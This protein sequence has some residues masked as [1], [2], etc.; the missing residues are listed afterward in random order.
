M[1]VFV[2]YSTDD[3]TSFYGTYFDVEEARKKIANLILLELSE[4]DED[5]D[6][7][8]LNALLVEK[9]WEE[10]HIYWNDQYNPEF[11]I[12]EVEIKNSEEEPDISGLLPT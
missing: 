2:V 4:W 1:D 6:D 7:D 11:Y 10:A 9:N 3:D 12:S 8:K 5:S